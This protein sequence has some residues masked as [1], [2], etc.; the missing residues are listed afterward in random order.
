MLSFHGQIALLHV[1]VYYI[2]G[3]YSVNLVGSSFITTI[4]IMSVGI[5]LSD[6][7]RSVYIVEHEVLH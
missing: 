1:Q 2:M 6:W 5:V 4:I 7:L 3:E